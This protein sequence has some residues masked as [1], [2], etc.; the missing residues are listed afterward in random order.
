MHK[1]WIYIWSAMISLSVLI[2]FAF[3]MSHRIAGPLYRL[4]M[5]MLK[6]ATGKKIKKLAF[7][8]KDYFQ[9]LA[10][11]F[12]EMNDATKPRQSVDETSGWGKHLK[13]DKKDSAA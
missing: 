5:A 10:D 1:T 11:S 4:K 7:R 9:E 2:W 8:E 13:K 3:R 12:N 6:T